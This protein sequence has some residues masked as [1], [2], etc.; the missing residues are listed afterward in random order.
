MKINKSINK[1]F[2]NRLVLKKIKKTPLINEIKFELFYTYI[3]NLD[4][5]YYEMRPVSKSEFFTLNEFNDK[6]NQLMNDL[7]YKI[8]F[9]YIIL[10]LFII[11][12]SILGFLFILFDEVDITIYILK[13]ILKITNIIELTDFVSTS[14]SILF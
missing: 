6:K 13:E 4:Y 1:I 14:L 9:K 10:F 3:K 5:L 8:P 2:R 11:A 7:F 12:T